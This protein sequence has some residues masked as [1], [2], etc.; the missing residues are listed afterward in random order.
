MVS[1]DDLREIARKQRDE[2]KKTG[3]GRDINRRS[4][5]SSSGLNTISC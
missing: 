3:V 2:R 1:F 5:G 4:A